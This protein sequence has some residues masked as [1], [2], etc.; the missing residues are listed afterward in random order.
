MEGRTYNLA[1]IALLEESFITQ[2]SPQQD[3]FW[4]FVGVGQQRDECLLIMD[5]CMQAIKDHAD[6]LLHEVDVC[7]SCLRP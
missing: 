1:F 5:M 7:N 2:H 3:T 4:F 6:H